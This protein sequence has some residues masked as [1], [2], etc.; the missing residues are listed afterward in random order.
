VFSLKRIAVLSAPVALLSMLVASG[1]A[2]ET[3]IYVTGTSIGTVDSST[4][5]TDNTSSNNSGGPLNYTLPNG[6]STIGAKVSPENQTLYLLVA[7][8]GVCQLYSVDTAGSSGSAAMTVVNSNYPCLPLPGTGDFAFLNYSGSASKTDSYVVADGSN[9]L[10]V[11]AGGGAATSIAVINS[12]GDEANIWGLADEGS[13][14]GDALNALYGVDVG[15]KQLFQLSLDANAQTGTETD[16]AAV[17]VT[18]SGNT[19]LDYSS[20]S[21]TLYLYTGS[22]LYA[23]G[24]IPY[25]NNV[26]AGAFPILGNMPAGTLAMAV[27]GNASVTNNSGALTPVTLLPLLALATLR[28]RRRGSAN[29]VSPAAA[30]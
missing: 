12:L 10:E 8:S 13:S 20:V 19:S 24:G 15:T 6:S 22:V 18:F 4:P 23:Y 27:A 2:A 29:A 30:R 17:P 14:A 3:L 9:I 11:P 25:P 28:R 5:G 21:S 16:I 7:N 1:A 26:S